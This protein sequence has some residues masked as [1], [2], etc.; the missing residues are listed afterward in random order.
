MSLNEFVLLSEVN[1]CKVDYRFLFIKD[2]NLY[3]VSHISVL[4]LKLG[5]LPRNDFRI[6]PIL[7]FFNLIFSTRIL[8]ALTY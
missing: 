6:E 5:A 1:Q 8:G 2:R 7:V 3:K 4:F